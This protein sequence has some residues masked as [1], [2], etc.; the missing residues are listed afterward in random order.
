MKT[1]LGFTF[2]AVTNMPVELEFET[3]YGDR[4]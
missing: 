2:T 3:L 4:S 1:I